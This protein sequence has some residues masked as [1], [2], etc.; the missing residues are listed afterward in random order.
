MYDR[1]KRVH[2]HSPRV[3]RRKNQVTNG[4][5]GDT[6]IAVNTDKVLSTF[7]TAVVSGVASALITRSITKNDE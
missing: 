3:R 5:E 4:D 7:V 1:D 2:G 6:E